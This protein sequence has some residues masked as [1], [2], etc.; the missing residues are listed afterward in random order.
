MAGLGAKAQQERFSA[1]LKNFD[2]IVAPSIRKGIKS[3]KTTDLRGL[4][5]LANHA[6]LPAFFPINARLAPDFIL[7]QWGIICVGEYRFEKKTGLPLRFRL[8]SLD[9]VNR[10]EGK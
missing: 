6:Q 7:Q 3:A 4:E 2:R 8:G 1:G 10:L 9:Y 5:P